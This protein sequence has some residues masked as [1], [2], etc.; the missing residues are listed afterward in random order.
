MRI[1]NSWGINAES[2]PDKEKRVAHPLDDA[3]QHV[4]IVASS[5]RTARSIKQRPV[6]K[7]G[8][9]LD[10]LVQDGTLQILVKVEALEDGL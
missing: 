10:A 5:I 4:A 2:D 6:I 8:K 9:T 3:N 1:S 7:R